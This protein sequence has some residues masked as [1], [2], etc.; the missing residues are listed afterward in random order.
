MSRARRASPSR[1]ATFDS[2][3]FRC[4]T[5]KLRTLRLDW[6]T[7]LT[8]KGLATL[9]HLER[10]TD[11]DLAHTKLDRHACSAIC[12]SLVRL[13]SLVLRGCA[14]S[15]T[16]LTSVTKLQRL[17]RLSL[18]SC[19]VSSATVDALMT[20]PELTHLD[21]AQTDVDDVGLHKIGEMA[22]LTSL[23][24]D[25]CPVGNHGLR[26]LAPLVNLTSLDLAD[27]DVPQ[28]HT[29]WL[30]GMSGLTNLNLFYAGVRRR[31]CC[32]GYAVDALATWRRDHRQRRDGAA[33]ATL[34]DEAQPRLT[35]DLR[36]RSR[37]P[38]RPPR[39]DA[40]RPI[41]REDHRHRCAEIF[42]EA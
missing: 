13:R 30:R 10:I 37:R 42:A 6:C 41:W 12:A 22:Q 32:A 8:S 33:P 21:L 14:L 25:A 24:L 38:R 27:I 26:G 39:A 11:L 28:L 18:R 3:P 36:L 40:S 15:D 20:L 16:A 31:R 4:R 17:R 9:P 34:I 19:A 23:C 35:L 29:D 7:R 2:A 1:C 5:G